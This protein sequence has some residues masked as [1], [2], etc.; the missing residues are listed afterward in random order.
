MEE[1]E[2][3]GWKKAKDKSANEVYFIFTQKE[4]KIF[5]LLRLQMLIS[6]QFSTLWISI[7]VELFLELLVSWFRQ[8][9][10]T[11][12]LLQ[13]LQSSLIFHPFDLLC[14]F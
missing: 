14:Q 3:A 12:K 1:L 7:R 8:L 11:V 10:K 4:K 2:T 9:K 6:N 5:I 13:P